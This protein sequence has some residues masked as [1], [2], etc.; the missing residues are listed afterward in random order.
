MRIEIPPDVSVDGHLVDGVLGYL[1]WATG[2]LFLVAVGVLVVSLVRDRA[3]PG[4][5]TGAYTHGDRRRDQLLTLA[6]GLIM[7]FAVDAVLPPGPTARSA[8]GSGATRTAIRGRCA[9]R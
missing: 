3:R 4:R 6:V 1:T 5:A 7:F 2:I 9:S 8:I